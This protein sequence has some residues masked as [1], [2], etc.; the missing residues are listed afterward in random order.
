MSDLP[1]MFIDPAIPKEKRDFYTT[2][3]SYPPSVVGN[4][5]S[6]LYVNHP[7]MGGNTEGGVDSRMPRSLLMNRSFASKPMKQFIPHELEHMLQYKVDER[8]QGKTNYDQEVVNEYAKRKGIPYNQARTKIMELLENAAK[9]KELKKHLQNKGYTPSGYF[10]VNIPNWA[11]L[12]E[13]FADL[14]AMEYQGKAPLTNDAVV[15]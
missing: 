6:M 14:S 9:N 7:E 2:N 3:Q 4:D 10:G 12:V 13:Q 15:S 1:G 11:N 5:L 8:Y